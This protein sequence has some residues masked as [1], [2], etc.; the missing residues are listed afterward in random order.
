MYVPDAD[1]ERREE[2]VPAGTELTHWPA[3]KDQ[4][5]D[6]EKAP[7]QFRTRAARHPACSVTLVL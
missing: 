5:Q 3:R 7:Q 6:P 1:G 2:Y 4:N